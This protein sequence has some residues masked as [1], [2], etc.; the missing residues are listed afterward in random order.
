MD[1]ADAYV[2]II[3]WLVPHKNAHPIFKCFF[4]NLLNYIF[5]NLYSQASPRAYYTLVCTPLFNNLVLS[6]YLFQAHFYLPRPCHPAK[7]NN[8][9]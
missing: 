7:E 9:L 4:L 3:K 6:P 2:L 8:L 1:A 5:F